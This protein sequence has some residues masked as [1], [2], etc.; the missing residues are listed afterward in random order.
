MRSASSCG[1]SGVILIAAP[2]WSPR[3][4]VGWSS[5]PDPDSSNNNDGV[6]DGQWLR[7]NSHTFQPSVGVVPMSATDDRRRACHDQ[8]T[9]LRSV[10]SSQTMVAIRL[11]GERRFFARLRI[12]IH[13]KQNRFREPPSLGSNAPI[14]ADRVHHPSIVKPALLRQNPVVR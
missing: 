3:R 9:C 1:S 7:T 6:R 5:R 13:Q 14:G 4:R 8:D 11:Q 2:S 10:Y 12:T